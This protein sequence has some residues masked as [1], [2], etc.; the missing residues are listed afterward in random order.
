MLG[1]LQLAHTLLI[2][3]MD[4]SANHST[5]SIRR[6]VKMEMEKRNVEMVEMIEMKDQGD[7]KKGESGDK[8]NEEQ[9]TSIVA[10]PKQWFL[11]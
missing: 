11:C 7:V 5:P 2:F 9:E 1:I 8:S 10:V 4:D 6:F 3:Y